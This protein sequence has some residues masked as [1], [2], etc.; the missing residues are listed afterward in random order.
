MEGATDKEV[1]WV[2]FAAVAIAG[3]SEITPA[4]AT[5]FANSMLKQHEKRFPQTEE[6]SN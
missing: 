1:L 3:N 5:V 4:Q 6:D 2:I